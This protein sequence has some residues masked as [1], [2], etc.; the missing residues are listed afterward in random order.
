VRLRG[1]LDDPVILM[2]QTTTTAKDSRNAGAESD[3]LL[4]LI[5]IE[6]SVRA[7]ALIV[8]GLVLITHPHT[9]WGKT[10]TDLSQHL[11]L[12]PSRN[13]IQRLITKVQAI[14]PNKYTIFGII[15][16][17]YGVLEGVEGYGLLRRRRWAEY[18][19][20]VAT[21]LLFIPEVYELTKTQTPLKVGALIAN[22]A[23]VVYLIVRLRRYGG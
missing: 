11:G 5:A 17:A 20:V 16:I 1:G 22:V 15:A 7:V 23:I 21:S 9:D 2:A 18:L 6:R 12:D 3:R 8:I 10:I 4:P 13:G 19:T 14:T